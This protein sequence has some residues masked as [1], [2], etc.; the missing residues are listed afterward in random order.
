MTTGRINQ[1]ENVQVVCG[2]MP[3]KNHITIKNGDS[4]TLQ[5][6]ELRSY[7]GSRLVKFVFRI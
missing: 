2:V 1:V 4:D 6:G 7:C 5:H 3:T